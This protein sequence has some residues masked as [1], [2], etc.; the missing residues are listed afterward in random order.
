MNAHQRGRLISRLSS[1]FIVTLFCA[2]LCASA[3]QAQSHT[4]T[5]TISDDVGKAVAQAQVSLLNVRQLSVTSTQ[6]DAQG[7]F[8]LNSVASGTY[9]LLV[10]GKGFEPRRRAVL[11]PRD[12]SS[13]LE[14]KLGL[15]ALTAEV[16][17][18]ADVGVVQSL[19]ET[20]QQVNVIDD[21]KLQ[22]RASSVL[23]QAAR[24][25]TGVSVQRTSATIGAIVVRGLTGAKVVNYVDG[26]RF[27]NSAARGGI[28]TFFNLN[29]VSNLRAIEVIRGPNSAQFGSDSLGGSVNLIS[30]PALYTNGGLEFHGRVS[31][32]YNSADHGFGGSTL[33][34][35]GGKDLSVL[36]NLA[37]HRSNTLRSGG[38]FDSHAAVNRFL[39]LRSSVL[40][41]DRSTD[42]AFTQYGGLLKLNYRLT[43]H[44]QLS[45]HYQRS[46]LDGG[47]RF[48][49]TLGGDGNLI[50][51]LRNFML[52]FFY[53]RYERF[54][55]G[56][57][58]TFAVSYS[59]NA[60]RE[61]RV[62]QG[63]NGNPSGAITFQPER[64]V[65]HGVQVQTTKQGGERNNL[66]LGGDFYYDRVRT[67][68]YSLNPVNGVATVVRGRVPDRA[69]YYN[70]GV[71]VQDVFTVI[72]K[73]LRLVGALRYGGVDYESRASYSP[74]VNG[75]PLWPS[76]SF[77]ADALTPRFGAVLTIFEG[78]NISGQISR[79]F[80]APHITDLGTIGLTGNGF[81][82]NAADLAGRGATVGS[83]AAATAVS[84][85]VPVQQLKPE[86][87]WTYEGGIHLHRSRIDIDVNGFV[88]DIKDN[89]AIQTLIL[90]QSAVGLQLGDQRVTSQNANG[91]IFVPASTNPVL[92]RANLDNAR[93]Y[94]IEQKFDLRISRSWTLG[95][96]FT[97]L[98]A[99]DDRTKLPPNIEGGTP[100]P[101]GYFRLR[102]EPARGRFWIEPYIYGARKQTRLSTLDL[103][104][105][106]TGAPRTRASIANFF[107]RGAAV[108]GLI[109]PGSDGRLGTADD[110]LKPTGETLAQVQ[111][112]MLGS[113]ASATLYPYIPGFMTINVRGGFRIGESHDVILDF[114]NLN[115][116]N[117]RG[118]SWGMDAP[119][120]SFGFRYNYRF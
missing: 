44:D 101:Q 31:T 114:E 79:G 58:D 15:A 116:K 63:G 27:S 90:P 76:D 113:A 98:H 108:R 14:I 11:L 75:Q 49:Q 7:K 16:T 67:D 40:D 89:I 118:I 17:I 111:T 109:S 112:R 26:I 97:Y 105:R 65:V 81:E 37:S 13:P 55:A 102:Y 4:L 48:D 82:A 103:E 117:Y 92:I 28:N 25:E 57:F 94:G 91:A 9:E 78:L 23:A 19:D 71:Y 53:G 95:Q 88:N 3:A 8:T 93:I 80:R 69:R 74:L 99:E 104:D 110:T 42:T 68:S 83:S 56:P 30:R 51:D 39:G 29:D 21:N 5:G 70:G 41:G 86:T 1:F 106:R 24:E 36:I 73:R 107:N 12:A 43:E 22:Q 62:N 6:T 60:Q 119:G 32:H 64:T 87:T 2:N 100:A 77:S 61:E 35:F 45:F 18:T 84:T 115:D 20:T 120:R 66:V 10:T 96:N 46:Q 38:G 33:G 72:P 47:K 54:Q 52:D 34:T 59:Y 85:G 50:A